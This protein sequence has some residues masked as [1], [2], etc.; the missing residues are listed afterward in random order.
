MA[1]CKMRGACSD[2]CGNIIAAMVRD[3]RK[4]MLTVLPDC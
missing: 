2:L 3:E 1:R 4:K